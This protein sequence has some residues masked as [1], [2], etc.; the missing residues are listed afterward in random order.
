MRYVCLMAVF[1]VFLSSPSGSAQTSA[2]GVDPANITIGQNLEAAATVSINGPVPP[3]GLKITI[4]SNDPSRLLLS[5]LPSGAGSASIVVNL[6]RGIREPDFF[7]QSLAKSGTVAY[8]ATAPG[9]SEGKG[10]VTLAPSGVIITGPYGI[11]KTMFQTTTGATK[12]KINVYSVVLDASLNYVARQA[13]AGGRTVK[14]SITNSNSS[15]GLL[16][17]SKVEIPGGGSAAIALFQPAA[18]GDTTL[19]I[20]VPDGFS[21]VAQYRAVTVKVSTPG[22]G[23]SEDVT[24]GQNLEAGGGISLGEAAPAGGLEI[25]L[26]SSSPSQVLLSTT[27]T[28]K[29]SPSITVKIPPGGTNATYYMQA[30]GATGPVT[31]SASA[32]GYRSRTAAAL[33]APSG[34]VVAGPLSFT[35]AGGSPGFATSLSAGKPTLIIV[36]TAFL[37]PKT[38]R[39]ADVT[40]QPLRPGVSLTVDLKCS[41]PSMGTVGT[42]V[43]FPSASDT[44]ET[45]FTPLKMGTMTLSV[46]TP[47]GFTQ[48]SNAT[49]LKVIITE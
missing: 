24:I 33:V 13:V 8:T 4:T 45:Q 12:T 31:V 7:L 42:P 3:N 28:E 14:A 9:Y 49:V 37:D 48:S 39:S 29:G 40:V 10:T 19:A 34:V 32:P 22:I 27:A 38:H 47:A 20:N 23:L 5:A 35:R 30:V 16:A 25:K 17:S 18:P 36:Y 43:T 6:Q 21:P 44:V 1:A 15:T 46:L 11:G 2:V 41:D 26:T